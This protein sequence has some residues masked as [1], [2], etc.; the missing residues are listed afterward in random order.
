MEP[1]KRQKQFKK[2]FKKL[3]NGLRK[4]QNDYRNGA[5]IMADFFDF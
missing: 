4:N 5:K 2:I 3:K 1:E